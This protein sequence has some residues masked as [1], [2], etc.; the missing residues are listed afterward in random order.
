MCRK[1]LLAQVTPAMM[2]KSRRSKFRMQAKY[3]ADH[4]KNASKVTRL[5]ERM[6]SKAFRGRATPAQWVDWIGKYPAMLATATE[7][8]L[9]A[10]RARPTMNAHRRVRSRSGCAD[11]NSPGR[12][13]TRSLALAMP[14]VVA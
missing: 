3:D 9:R 10:L 11:D 12:P 4:V 2:A 6:L 8:E 13:E 14:G 5:A 1:S 7:W